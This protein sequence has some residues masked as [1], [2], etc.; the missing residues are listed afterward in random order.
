MGFDIG[1]VLDYCHEIR[2]VIE[3]LREKEVAYVRRIKR[4]SM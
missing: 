2:S 1:N 3:F 4:T